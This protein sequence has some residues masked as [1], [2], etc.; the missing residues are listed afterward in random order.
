MAVTATN[1]SMSRRALACVLSAPLVPVAFGK[2]TPAASAT[3]RNGTLAIPDDAELFE[4]LRL[5][6]EANDAQD[7]A[8]DSLDAAYSRFQELG[9]NPKMPE[10]LLYREEDR[11]LGLHN[12]AG[13]PNG[14]EERQYPR[15]AVVF[16]KQSPRRKRFETTRPGTLA[17]GFTQQEIDDWQANVLKVHYEPWPEA[18]ARADEIV[19][20][21]DGWI[22]ESARR[23]DVSGATAA[24]KLHDER[25][26]LFRAAAMR[27]VR[28]PARTMEGVRAKVAVIMAIYNGDHEDL[29]ENWADDA[30]DVALAVSVIAD[31]S[32]MNIPAA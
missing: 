26:G 29:I 7:A 8:I 20:A 31:I 15:S 25:H 12:L 6:N 11:D 18:Q 1:T 4:A 10:A 28:T 30:T 21:W 19:A 32:R 5:Y 13:Y 27:L 24:K 16:L 9:G 2:M 22:A 3:S 14:A 23:R 17:E